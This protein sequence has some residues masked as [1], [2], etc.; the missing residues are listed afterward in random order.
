MRTTTNIDEI[1]TLGKLF[2]VSAALTIA[3]AELPKAARRGV[4]D[5]QLKTLPTAV[6]LLA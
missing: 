2:S 6:P 4:I 3:V 1:G 5:L